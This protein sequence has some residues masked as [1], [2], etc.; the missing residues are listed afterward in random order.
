MAS[1]RISTDPYDYSVYTCP[2]CGQR[3]VSVHSSDPE[4]IL[5]CDDCEVRF[6]PSDDEEIVIRRAVRAGKDPFH[7]VWKMWDNE[8]RVGQPLS[9]D[10]DDRVAA[11][12]VYPDLYSEEAVNKRRF[13]E[14]VVMLGCLTFGTV[15]IILLF[16]S[17]YRCG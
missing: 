12:V 1:K 15:F 16:I 11:S 3:A 13:R 5:R 8:E 17:A 14:N 7:G 6:Y 2:R 9:L 4:V 10:L